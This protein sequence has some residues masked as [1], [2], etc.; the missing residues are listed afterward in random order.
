VREPLA[1][2]VINNHNYDR[3]LGEAIDSALVQ[4]YANLEVI[5]VDD[6][7]TDASREILEAY[8][9]RARMVLK[10]NGGQASALNAGFAAAE[11][12]V[13]CFLDAD[14]V[15]RPSAI[16]RAVAGLLRRDTVKAH[17]PM[18]EIDEAGR[19]TGGLRPGDPLPDGDCQAVLVQ[20]GPELLRYPPTSGNAWSRRFLERVMPVPEIDTYHFGGSDAYLS[21]LAPLYGPVRRIEEPQTFYRLHGSN[22]YAALAFERRL[23]QN[24]ACYDE[25]CESLAAHCRTLGID[26]DS[27]GWRQHSWLHQFRLARE[28][29]G[30]VIPPG[31]QFVLV[32]QAQVGPE[33][34][35]GRR[36][37]PLVERDGESWGAPDDD[38]SAIGELER[39]RRLGADFIAF[40]WPAFWWLDYY[41]AFSDYLRSNARR[42]LDNER[43]VVFDLRT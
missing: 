11:G 33:I 28:E 17:W 22:N 2:I 27:D 38:D 10:A 1:S 42:I 14:D 20:E 23:E 32:D 30:A 18:L 9:E 34:A 4:S 43:L 36:V 6:G 24:L 3:F 31:T 39:Q 13:V 16:E 26:A 19:Q 7:S 41:A 8:D 29:L 35:P 15:L 25:L 21:T 5:V 40:T 12:A 37:V